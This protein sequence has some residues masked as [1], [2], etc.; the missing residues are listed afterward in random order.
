MAEH[1]NIRLPAEWE[2]QYG[3]QLTWPHE[4]SDW[5]DHLAEVEAC[6]VEIAKE[7]S[8]HERVLIVCPDTRHV[9]ALLQKAE[10]RVDQIA[11][12]H[13]PSNDTW[14][15]DHGPI[16][17][18]ENDTPLL[19]D[20]A[21][22]GWGLRFPANLDNELSRSLH[23]KGV[24][25]GA[26]LRT[27]GL[28]LEG[29]AI[30]SDGQGSILTT[31]YCLLSPNRNPHLDQA[32][33]ETQLCEFLG[34]QRILWLSHGFLQGD[35]TDSHVDTLARFCDACTIA[36]VGCDDPDDPH[37]EE[38]GAM[39]AE[40]KALTAPDGESYSLVRLPMPSAKYDS[41]LNRLPATYANFLIINSAVLLPTYNDPLDETALELLTQCFPGR[42]LIGIDCSSLILQHGSL[43]CVTMQFPKGV[44]F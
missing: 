11:L 6:F 41:E 14:T 37:Y 16:T 31:K 7:I 23:R 2:P 9:A 19:L 4:H 40:L 13:A 5:R 10:A 20:F 35:D 36:Y 30:E 1:K 22:N 24:L 39:E 12:T 3:V 25:K 15:R 42:T 32:Q 17:V 38:L 28:V 26:D 33:L 27:L 8:F 43:H 21:F 29:G 18:F 34:A 44:R